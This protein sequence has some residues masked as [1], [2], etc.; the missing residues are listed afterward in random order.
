MINLN[1]SDSIALKNNIMKTNKTLWVSHT[2]IKKIS[3][4]KGHSIACDFLVGML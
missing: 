2:S 4:K 3:I 1:G